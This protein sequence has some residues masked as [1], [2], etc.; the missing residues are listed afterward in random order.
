MAKATPKAAKPV[1]GIKSTPAPDFKTLYSN[2]VS[3]SVSTWDFKLRFGVVTA[4]EE[5]GLS[6]TDWCEIYMA[7]EHVVALVKALDI[8]IKSYQETY[9]PIRDADATRQRAKAKA[10]GP[11][12]GS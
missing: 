9:G 3:L 2:N 5:D 1:R 6:V 7:P 4:A 11:S 12:N 8:N 10:S